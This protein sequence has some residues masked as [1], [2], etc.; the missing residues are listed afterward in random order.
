MEFTLKISDNWVEVLKMIR[1][2][3]QQTWGYI[4]R[5]S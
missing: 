2:T 3:E 1:L 4:T 5:N